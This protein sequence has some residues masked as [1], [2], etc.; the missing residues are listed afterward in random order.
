MDEWS[1]GVDGGGTHVRAKLFCGDVVV[2]EAVGPAVNPRIVGVETA[3]E[4]IVAAIV[5]LEAKSPGVRRPD[6]IAC[7]I[8]GTGDPER[9]SALKAALDRAL[10][11]DV[12]LFTDA[13]AALFAAGEDAW[14]MIVIAG[15]GSIALARGD[16][17]VV[18]RSGGLGHERG[19]PGS[20]TR[21]GHDAL[22]GL[23]SSELSAEFARELVDARD[24]VG[25]AE[26]AR[27]VDRWANR[28]DRDALRILEAAGVSLADEAIACAR[29][30]DPASARSWAIAWTGSVF[31]HA[32]EVR[33]ATERRLRSQGLRFF[34]YVLGHPAEIGAVRAARAAGYPRAKS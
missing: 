31:L 7:G 5:A 11:R 27:I 19:D 22:D 32:R 34:A 21:I 14:T 10:D 3:C 2:A 9:R 15:T 20:A 4:R 17:G 16:G 30:L 6:L 12:F 24:R 8:A 23:K 18:V 28:G 25:V 29:K 26:L 1:I 33:E 13:E